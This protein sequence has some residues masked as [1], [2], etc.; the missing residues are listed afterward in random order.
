MGRL[1]GKVILVAG[2]GGIGGALARRYAQEGARVVLG[3]L[4][5]A[6]AQDVVNDI[7]SAGHVADA[8]GLDGADEQSAAAA[9]THCLD[10]HGGLDGLHVNFASFADGDQSLSVLELP[11]EVFDE[12][13]RVNSRGF[14][15]VTRAALPVLI[16]RGGGSIIYTSS[17]AAYDSGNG[18][19]A[20][21]MSKAAGQA[22]MRHV[23]RRFGAEG[24]RANA[25][26]PALTLPPS[27]EPHLPTGMLDWARSKAAIK[28][29]IGR[30]EDIAAMGVL[31]MSDE[32]AYITGQVICVDG[33]TVMRS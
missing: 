1:E 19:V 9:V 24:I 29:R 30:P 31:L 15:V 8:L 5:L 6:V 20:Y 28:S 33:G 14:F 21:A 18:Q 32:G 16:A 10:Q 4:Q 13:H 11:F 26:A 22:L 3:D 23:A 17:V 25:I 2:A 27:V 7:R 12:V